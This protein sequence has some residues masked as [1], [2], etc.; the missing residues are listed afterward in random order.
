ME[1]SPGYQNKKLGAIHIN[2]INP[3][4]HIGETHGIYKIIDVSSNKKGYR[5]LYVVECLV[6]GKIFEKAYCK[7]SGSGEVK[8]CRHQNYGE[9]EISRYCIECG[10]K[11]E[12]KGLSLSKYR[13]R[14]FCSNTCANS[15]RAKNN[16]KRCRHCGSEIPKN[17]QFCSLNC[18]HEYQHSQ[19]IMA[20]K[21]GD[22]SG[23]TGKNWIDVSVHIRRYIFEKYDNKCSRCGWGE[24]N[25]YTLTIP[26]EIEHIDGDATN[27]TEDNLTLLCPNCHS[28]TETYR[29]ANKGNGTRGIKWI[30]RSG[31][32]NIEI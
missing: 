21:N 26:L 24:V 16:I 6:C 25:P 4:Q 10:R 9:N 5:T 32:T 22:K 13:R 14:K 2:K 1:S 12:R 20:W 3:T 11:I 27:N 15:H 18:F 31:T 30:S 23:A 29:G 19:Y 17:N 28:L 8:T 7:I